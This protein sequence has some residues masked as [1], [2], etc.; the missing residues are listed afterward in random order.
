MLVVVTSFEQVFVRFSA[1]ANYILF[2][3]V[4]LFHNIISAMLSETDVRA[5]LVIKRLV[6]WDLNVICWH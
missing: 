5:L 2:R 3:R 1:L 4:I 6:H